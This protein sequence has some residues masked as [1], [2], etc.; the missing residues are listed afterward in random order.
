MSHLNYDSNESEL[1]YMKG[2][3]TES[4]GANEYIFRHARCISHRP[5]IYESFSTLNNTYSF[6]ISDL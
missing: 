3:W 2:I 5:M 1:N 6:A 4:V